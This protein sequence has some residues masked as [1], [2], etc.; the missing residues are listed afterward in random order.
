MLNKWLR[1]SLTAETVVETIEAEKFDGLKP[2]RILLA[3]FIMGVLKEKH[4][5]KNK[6][7]Q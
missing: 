3:E 4:Q 2:P 7:R 6:R 5:L 1:S